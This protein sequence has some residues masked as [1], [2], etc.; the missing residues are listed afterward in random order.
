MPPIFFAGGGGG[1]FG[2]GT[3]PA[4]GAA[5]AAPDGFADFAACWGGCGACGAGI[6]A[7]G[8][9]R[10]GGG[11]MPPIFFA[12]GCNAGGASQLVGLDIDLATAALA[13]QLVWV[14]RLRHL[15]WGREWVDIDPAT[16]CPLLWIVCVVVDPTTPSLPMPATL[17][18][19]L[20]RHESSW[21]K[22][23]GG[24][25]SASTLKLIM[26]VECR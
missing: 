21:R 17:P 13:S 10:G 14:P 24:P 18:A 16:G 6:A 9:F 8:G 11:G 15:L 22:R 5:T 25:L 1:F 20:L 26:C 2:F 12:A 23:V 7:S 19:V 3:G 4:C